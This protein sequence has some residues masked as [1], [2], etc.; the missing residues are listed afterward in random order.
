MS[1]VMKTVSDLG[2]LYCHVACFRLIPATL[3]KTQ[4]GKQNTS[5]QKK[6]AIEVR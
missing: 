6:R 2:L 5:V 1:D 4:G 3:L